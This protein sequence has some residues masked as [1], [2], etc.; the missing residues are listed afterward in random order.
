MERTLVLIKPDA[1]ERALVGRILS[2]FEEKGLKLA[3]LK[4]LM[5]TK[6]L[7][8]EHYRHLVDKPF[9]PEI[10]DFMGSI[11]VVAVCLEG[12]DAVDVVR[13]MTGITQ[14]REAAPGTIRGDYAMSI[15]CNL[16]HAS[17]SLAAASEE[18]ARFFQPAELFGYALRVEPIIYAPK[19]R[20]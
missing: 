2:R 4:M 8:T 5:L 19:E 3:G 15:Q 11:P 6:E 17:D 16:V 18:I 10:A 20:Q 14:S 13:R 7:L 1:L 9:Y 12:K